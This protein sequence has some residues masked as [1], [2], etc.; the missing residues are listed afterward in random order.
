MTNS[1]LEIAREALGYI[2]AK[3]RDLWVKVGMALKA[4]LGET[5][6]DLYDA[7]SR[8]SPNYSESDTR[9]T[10]KSYKTGVAPNGGRPIGFGSL[11]HEAKQRGFS[12]NGEFKPHQPTPEELAKREFQAQAERDKTERGYVH[13]AE[14]ALRI[15]NDSQPLQAD[16]LNPYLARKG[17]QP[18][19]TMRESTADQIESILGYRPSG[20]G[21]QQIQGRTLVIPA[22]IDGKLSTVELIDESGTKT[23]LAGSKRV[24]SFWASEKLPESDGTGLIIVI[25]EGVAT[26]LSPRQVFECVGVAAFSNSN[27]PQVAKAERERSPAALLIILAD[28]D[29]MTGEPD[30][31]AVEAA[32]AGGA[33][34]AVPDFG[35]DRD[36]SH[37]DWNDLLVLRGP[38]EVRAQ[39]EA[40]I[41][42]ECYGSSPNDV[43]TGTILVNNE[44][45][46]GESKQA[47]ETPNPTPGESI[48][49]EDEDLLKTLAKLSPIEYDR[50]RQKEAKALKVRVETLDAEVKKRQPEQVTTTS[51]RML[52]IVKPIPVEKP[53]MG[54]LLANNIR[55]VFTKHIILSPHMNVVLTLWVINTY[56]F[57]CFR[58]LPIL[59]L[60]SAQ[61]RC[62]KTSTLDVIDGLV[63]QPLAASNITPSALFRSVEKWC[64]TLLVDEVDSFVKDNEELRGIINSGHTRT[65]AFVIRTVGDDHEPRQF[66]TWCPKVLAGIGDLP[67]TI[68]DRSIVVKLRRKLAGESV[69]KVTEGDRKKMAGMTRQ[70]MRWSIDNASR[71]RRANPVVPRIANDRASDN[72]FPL[73]AIADALD[74]DWPK[75]ARDAMNSLTN[76]EEDESAG[77]VLL[78]DIEGIFEAK[79]TGEITS[80]DL[81]SALV[82]IE[83]SPW[84]EWNRGKPIM[85]RQVARLL[86]PFEIKPD[87][88]RIGKV[89]LK[90]YKKSQFADASSR[91]LPKTGIRSGTPEHFFNNKEIR[92]NQSGTE[93]FCV[94]DRNAHNALINNDCSGVP[95]ENTKYDAAAGTDDREGLEL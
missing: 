83:D 58:T 66:S 72:W 18:T 73:L 37:K 8:T 36:P 24:G 47:E 15:W 82:G 59:S 31:H 60:A 68:A 79:K 17:I 76:V 35:P 16:N 46:E 20:K 69:A 41:S 4:E 23:T 48:P 39:I 40:V 28:L 49:L 94:P 13:A 30:R 3:D 71:L 65:S 64:P 12:P 54:D 57:D 9:I 75:L 62:G 91:Y 89:T 50:R 78:E 92:S 25:G 55:A 14:H 11:L 22:K 85:P 86:K 5:G 81:V 10:W 29:K 43:V 67:D 2:P 77:V 90:G 52:E 53:V 26:A 56:V 74:G 34:L 21:G 1:N 45:K 7:W 93:G 44:I 42:G 51:G 88:L 38:E 63:C 27:L 6:F 61:K 84:P 80:A 70:I 95:D 87:S 32:R 19:L 33:I